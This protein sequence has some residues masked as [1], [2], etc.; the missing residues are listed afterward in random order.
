MNGKYDQDE[1]RLHKDA[2]EQAYTALDDERRVKVLSP[3]MLVLRRFMRSKLAITGL[4]ILVLMFTFSFIGGLLSPYGESQVFKTYEQSPT[5]YANAIYNRELRY[6]VMEGI[7]F[8]NAA[9]A[10]MVLAVNSG[11]T[12]FTGFD[13]EIYQLEVLGDDLYAVSSTI[14]V[15]KVHVLKAFYDYE[16]L[17]GGIEITEDFKAAFEAAQS[18]GEE[19]MVYK[20][21]AYSIIQN[22]RD[23]DVCIPTEIAVASLKVFDAYNHADLPVV[24][25]VSFRIAAEVAANNQA[26]TF[27][28]DGVR[29]GLEYEEGNVI[30]L[31]DGEHFAA[32][33]DIIVNPTASD[34]TLSFEFKEQARK[35]IDDKL[36]SFVMTD[37]N[38]EERLYTITR[39]NANFVIRTD[40]L[41][42]LIDMYAP[43]SAEHPLGTDANGM[44]VLTRLMYGGRVSLMVGFVVVLIELVIGVVLGGVSGY[45][46]GWVDTVIMRF[47]DLFNCIPTMPMLLI[48]VSILDAYKVTP[49]IRIYLLMVLL[50]IMGWTGIARTVR[51]QIL[52][53][54]E[55]DFMVATEATGI[56]VKRRIF[57]HLMPN[58]MPLLI[59]NATMN[60]GQII[61]TEATLSFLGLGVKYPLASWGTII[62]AATNIYVMT[63]YWFIWMPAGLLILATVLGFNF[64]G[65][66]LRDAFDPKMRR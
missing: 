54:R 61:I 47:V 1:K 57:R 33:S 43:P 62:N 17:P 39:S 56:S 51:G 63:N 10:K 55:Q 27:E 24:N 2:D 7:T 65:D 58:V 28:H 8:D 5:Q 52:S 44:D 25:S 48:L 26:Q 29:Y 60:L 12:S 14:T 19:T 37:E 30:I 46:G 59:V 53:L 32:I 20:G 16:D 66:G 6:T 35:A 21:E 31:K 49:Q 34:I 40:M 9:R 36:E 23:Y 42:E 50:G 64:V 15:A 13:G 38:G 41:T 11:E 22:D 45:F 3:T 18:A 4:I